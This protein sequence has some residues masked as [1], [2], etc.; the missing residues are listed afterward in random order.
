MSNYSINMETAGYRATVA[1][2]ALD[3]TFIG[4][5]ENYM[6]LHYFW[7]HEYKYYLRPTTVSQ[8]KRVHKKWLAAGLDITAVSQ[9]HLNII[10][11][12]LKMENTNV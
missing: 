5:P 3:E 12:V 4:D 8:K 6:G 11:Q 1:L 10:K 9:A 7:N 2:Y